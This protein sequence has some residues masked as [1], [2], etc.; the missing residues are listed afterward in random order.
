MADDLTPTPA[1]PRVRRGHALAV[2]AAG[3]LLVFCSVLPWAG[4]EATSSL[5]PGAVA[6]D[7]RG[8]DDPYGVYTLMAGLVVLGCGLAGLLS[9]FPRLAALAAVP[10]GVAMVTLLRFVT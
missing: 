8:I 7:V 6:D 2:T 3:A 10:A 5:I 4:V 1:R 9:A